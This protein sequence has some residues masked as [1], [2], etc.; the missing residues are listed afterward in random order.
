M[1]LQERIQDDL[2]TALKA[3]DAFRL[4]TLR[5]VKSA[6]HNREIEKK[7]KGGDDVLT[8][9]EALDVLIKEV[10]K[11]TESRDIYKEAGR[12][13]LSEKESAELVVLQPYLPAEATDEELE[14]AVREAISQFSGATQ[15]EFGKIMGVVMKTMK[16]RASSDR[17][18]AL[19]RTILS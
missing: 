2:K 5:L 1:S 3:H 19:I 15:K 6:L 7:G 11:R 12:M 10:K 18:M 4:E 16:G 8:D 13:D 17:I 9:D 14:K